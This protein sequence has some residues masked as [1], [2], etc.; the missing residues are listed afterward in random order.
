M[1]A[2][3]GYIN[4]GKNRS[5]QVSSCTEKRFSSL[6]TRFAFIPAGSFASLIL[7]LIQN[8]KGF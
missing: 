4:S 8:Y 7:M 2:G 5:Y 6:S 3:V 1:V